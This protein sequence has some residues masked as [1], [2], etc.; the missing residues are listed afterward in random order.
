MNSR[1]TLIVGLTLTLAG[2]SLSPTKSGE[3]SL[4]TVAEITETRPGN[5]TVT[6]SGRIIITNH[7]LDAPK[8]RV[9]ELLSD[10]SVRPF[11][12]L[13][14]ADGP[15]VGEVGIASTIGIGTSTQGVVWILD[16]GDERVP[17]KL[18]GWDTIHDR[19]HRTLPITPSAL[20]A[21]S[22]LQDFAIDEKREKIYIADMTFPGPG[23]AAAP[24]FVVVDLKTGRCARVL[25]NA[26]ALRPVAEDVVIDGSLVGGAPDTPHHLGVNP[27]AIDPSFEWVYFGT[28]NGDDVFRI[29][30]AALANAALSDRAREQQIERYAEKRPS[31]G[32]AVDDRGR[33]FI[34]DIEGSAVGVSTPSGYRVI[35][36]DDVRLCWPDGFALGPDNALYVTQNHLH[37]HPGL[38]EGVDETVRPFH[39]LRIPLGDLD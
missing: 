17:P 29:P 18:V 10:G 32:I 3:R 19:L 21:T 26:A 12:T 2:C 38:N 39:I 23:Q 4:E 35:A 8:L 22:F 34:T 37:G 31:D 7:P 11:P 33:V 36:Q 28:I 27:I 30:A 25:E 13:D 1:L 6:P 24:A 15:A 9:V 20:A 14:W 5:L 16:M